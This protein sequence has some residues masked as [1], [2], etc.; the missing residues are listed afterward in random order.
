MQNKTGRIFQHFQKRLYI[1]LLFSLTKQV[2]RK[3][4]EWAITN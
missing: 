3:K 1:F 4:L 2:K